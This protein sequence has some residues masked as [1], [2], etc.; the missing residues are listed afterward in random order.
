[1]D[2]VKRISS[3]ILEK[4]RDKFNDNFDDNKKAIKAIAIIRSKVL[5]NKVAGY[6]TS[7][8]RKESTTVSLSQSSESLDVGQTS[9][10][11]NQ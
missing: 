4:Y 8:L 6:I 11:E 7:Y 3:E 10:L 5:R 1:M 2:R 9:I